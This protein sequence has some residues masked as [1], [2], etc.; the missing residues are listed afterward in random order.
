MQVFY[1]HYVNIQV[2]FHIKVDNLIP[3][4]K[5]YM[6][7]MLMLSSVIIVLLLATFDGCSV[8]SKNNIWTVIHLKNINHEHLYKIVRNRA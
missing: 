3:K 1:V 7:I 8:L 6:S 2:H 4:Y 5:N